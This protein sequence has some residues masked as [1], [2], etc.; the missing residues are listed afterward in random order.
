VAHGERLATLL[1]LPTLSQL[2]DKSTEVDD[3]AVSSS[4]AVRDA[5]A[6]N[7]QSV[8][9]KMLPRRFVVADLGC[10]HGGL[11][12]TV[13]PPHPQMLCYGVDFSAGLIEQGARA[14]PHLS[15]K[16][17]VV[18]PHVPSGTVDAVVSNAVIGMIKYPDVCRHIREIARLLRPGGA[19]VL[20]Q[21]SLSKWGLFHPTF[22]ADDPSFFLRTDSAALAAEF[23]PSWSK[24]DVN[25]DPAA[26]DNSGFSIA[27]NRVLSRCPGRIG[28]FFKRVEIIADDPLLS[29]YTPSFTRSNNVAEAFARTE[30]VVRL[31]R[32]TVPFDQR[33]ESHEGRFHGDTNLIE[34]G[35][36][37]QAPPGLLN[38]L[39]KDSNGT[40]WREY[41]TAYRDLILKAARCKTM[42][43]SIS[44]ARGWCLQDQPP[45]QGELFS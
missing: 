34:N 15:L 7:D 3:F 39:D 21:A 36:S 18:A 1:G 38:L 43:K 29:I 42:T 17:G 35:P 26:V 41:R 6:L 20:V 27:A 2:L 11:L 23:F 24:L 16:H 10:G 9:S 44:G 45:Q 30:F 4:K 12:S 14:F 13:C 19:A 22:F 31:F 37:L 28:R 8:L 32:S 40:A 25:V 33:R 5:V